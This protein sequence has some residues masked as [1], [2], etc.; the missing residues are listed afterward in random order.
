MKKLKIIYTG[1]TIGGK[2]D[3]S[4]NIIDE[5]VKGKNFK[6]LLIN[7]FPE[8]KGKVELST[9]TPINKFSENIIPTDW[10]K[11]ATA[12][13]NACEEAA[14]SIVIAHGTD[15]MCFTSSALSFML[16]GL[17]IPVILTGANYPLERSNTDAVRNMS[18]AIKVALDNRFKGVFLVFSGSAT[19]WSDIHLGCRARKKASFDYNHFETVNG[20]IMGNLKKG[21]LDMEPRISILNPK[22][23]RFVTKLNESKKFELKKDINDKIAFFKIYPGFNPDLIDNVVEKKAVKGIILELY[24]SGTGCV[25]DGKYSL[26]KCIE[27]A[28]SKNYGIP[29]FATSQ[30][31]GKVNM[32]T[33]VSSRKL[34]DA[35]V[36]P[37]GDMITEAAIPKL[38]WALGQFDS[39]QDVIKLMTENI[40]GEIGDE[41]EY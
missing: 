17:K 26:V 11:I 13:Y 7:K 28:T 1:G 36:T 30:H 10:I 27:K 4:D 6:S 31:Q 40:S 8:L 15:T 33:Y 18:D 20:Q 39:K 41:C 23:L 9:V 32:D 35:G 14:D 12:V 22:L 19:K 24:E 37:L 5:E 29:V 2:F 16:Q 21:F 3:N 38:M 25:D 34:L